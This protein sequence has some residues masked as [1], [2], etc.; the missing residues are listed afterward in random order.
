LRFAFRQTVRSI[1]LATFLAIIAYA[2]D[3]R[4]QLPPLK[5]ATPLATQM[6]QDAAST[7]MV[8]VLVRDREVSVQAY[9]ETA[10][11]SGRPPTADS[12]LRLCSLSKLFAADLLVKLT[13]D[14][15]VSL[16]SPLQHFAPPHVLVPTRT[17]RGK[18]E[19][20]I[21]LEDLATHTSGLPREVGAAPKGTPHFTFPNR[22]YR[23]RWLPGQIL[24]SSPGRAA[25]Y[26]NVGFDLLG[27]ALET[28][29]GKP[30]ARLLAER[31]TTPLGLRETTLTPTADQCSSL[32]IGADDEGPCTDTQASSGSSGV[33]STANDMVRWLRYLLGLPGVPAHQDP[34]AQA[35]YLLPASLISVSGLDHAGQPS[36]IG[37]AW[38]KLG[39][40]GD[41]GEV[42]EKTGGGAGFST[43]IALN[44]AHH[45]G[46]F[47][48]ATDGGPSQKNLF[49]D[50]NDLLMFI[51]G[52]PP[53]PREPQVKPRPAQPRRRK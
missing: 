18:T 17:R 5:A 19:R 47:V 34:A 52:L 20:G 25:L 37:L 40:A 11:G 29:A 50:A 43:Y 35:T 14:G 31:T 10:P 36:G 7:G 12:F 28:A 16:T 6:F 8:V 23:W 41:P 38:I 24:R 33:Y 32:L 46:I 3:L 44:P 26:S 22:P 15:T 42:L 51:S 2:S 30:Y 39:A 49:K 1:S 48:A 53:L 13:H 9:G 21:T 4:A 27:D 45:T